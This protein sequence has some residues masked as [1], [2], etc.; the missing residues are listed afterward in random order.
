MRHLENGNF[1]TMKIGHE[2]ERL[3]QRGRQA[4]L[5]QVVATKDKNPWNTRFNTV[6][7]QLLKLKAEKQTENSTFSQPGLEIL[8][9]ALEFLPS[10]PG[11]HE[12]PCAEGAVPAHKAARNEPWEQLQLMQ[13]GGWTGLLACSRQAART[14]P[15]AI[16]KVQSAG[17]SVHKWPRKERGGAEPGFKET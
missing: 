1:L 9:Y 3:H 5:A 8:V 16:G 17:N 6:Y 11:K 15:H 4:F 14:S 2:L 12:A 13:E 10:H 7:A